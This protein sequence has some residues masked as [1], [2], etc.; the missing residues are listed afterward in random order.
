MDFLRKLFGKDKLAIVKKEILSV[1]N[2]LRELIEYSVDSET[3]IRRL[4]DAYNSNS[5][6]CLL[7]AYNYFQVGIQQQYNHRVEIKRRLNDSKELKDI[8]L[9]LA[10]I[11]LCL[12]NKLYYFKTI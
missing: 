6:L 8:V 10:T 1:Q 2:S 3:D 7:D 9:F 12:G 5:H 11:G 4:L